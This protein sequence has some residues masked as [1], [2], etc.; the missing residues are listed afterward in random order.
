MILW[1]GFWNHNL[2]RKRRKERTK[3]KKRV[4][5]GRGGPNTVKEKS[6]GGSLGFKSKRWSHKALGPTAPG[7]WELLVWRPLWPQKWQGNSYP[8]V[9]AKPLLPRAPQSSSDRHSKALFENP[10]RTLRGSVGQCLHTGSLHRETAALGS[11]AQ[12]GEAERQEGEVGCSDLPQSTGVGG[13]GNSPLCTPH[14]QDDGRSWL[15]IQDSRRAEQFKGGVGVVDELGVVVNQ[16]GLDVVKDKS[17]LIWPLHRVQAWP[18]VRGQRGC[19]AGQG[20]GVHNF[21]HL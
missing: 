7:D 11:K 5:K 2:E 4:G 8:Q 3:G 1:Q 18:V 9:T 14:L 20:G 6:G 17:E 21:T 12:T 19:Q 15:L 10:T 16:Q 13:G